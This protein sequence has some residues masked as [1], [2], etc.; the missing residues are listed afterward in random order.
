MA[1]CRLWLLTLHLL[2]LLEMIEADVVEA[3]A[4]VLSRCVCEAANHDVAFVKVIL[5]DAVVHYTEQH[6]VGIA[7]GGLLEILKD[8]VLSAPLVPV[9]G[10]SALCRVDFTNSSLKLHGSEK[11]C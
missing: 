10:C 3:S 6:A 4:L 7:V 2:D 5:L 9:G 8:E 11:L 1:L